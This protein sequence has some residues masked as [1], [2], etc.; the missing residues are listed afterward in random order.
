MAPTCP[1]EDHSDGN[2]A[3]PNPERAAT[4]EAREEPL[5]KALEASATK[6][7][8]EEPIADEDR[9]FLSPEQPEATSTPSDEPAAAAQDGATAESTVAGSD[10]D[11]RREYTESGMGQKR[12]LVA[13]RVTEKKNRVA[14]VQ[15]SWKNHAIQMVEA[16]GIRPRRRKSLENQAFRCTDKGLINGHRG[17]R[18]DV[19]G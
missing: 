17:T 2:V 14:H 15:K 7:P 18:R 6:A 19:S 1:A 12:R 16:P 8:A 9:F 3:E 4:L 11:D 13:D 5:V 10:V